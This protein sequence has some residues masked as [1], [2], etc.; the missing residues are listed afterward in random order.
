MPIV[1]RI[2]SLGWAIM[3]IMSIANVADGAIPNDLLEKI[4]IINKDGPYL[5]IV[6]PNSFEMNP[7]LQSSSFVPHPMLSYLDFA[8]RRFRL[9]TLESRKVI[10]VMSGLSMLNA[11]LV[12]QLLLSIF[13]IEGVVHFGIAGNANPNL[14]IGDVTIPHYWA[15]SS[16]WNWQRF[17]D[18][19]DDE[20]AFE[21]NGDYTRKI[22]YLNFSQYENGTK[23]GNYSDNLLNNVWYQPEEIFSIDGQPE[24]RQHAFWVPVDKL[25]FSLAEYERHWPVISAIAKD[26]LTPPISTVISESAFSAGLGEMKPTS[27]VLQLANRSTIRPRRVVEDVLAQVDKFHYPIDFLVLDVNVEG[28][29]SAKIDYDPLNSFVLNS[30]ILIGSDID[31]YANICVVFLQNCRTIGLRH[32]NPSLKN[33]PKGLEDKNHQA[34]RALSRN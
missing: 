22:G 7:L 19:P 16:L 31:E 4:S 2:L 32:D 11:G 1:V 28:E 25:Y 30:E 13:E 34:L 14:Q 29:V 21:S 24:I 9:G 15:H 20:L 17:G 23:N 26:L 12:T 6:V 27:V 8:G 3:M 18:G 10:I 5:G 33:C